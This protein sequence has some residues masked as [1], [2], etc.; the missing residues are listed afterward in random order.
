MSRTSWVLVLVSPL[1]LLSCVL[2][3]KSRKKWRVVTPQDQTATVKS[4]APLSYPNTAEV[5]GGTVKEDPIVAEQQDPAAVA[6]NN[7]TAIEVIESKAWYESNDY[8]SLRLQV[9]QK[10]TEIVLWGKRMQ[11]ILSSRE[12]YAKAT[13]T[14][15]LVKLSNSA[16]QMK[17]LQMWDAVL[18]CQVALVMKMITL[19]Q[20]LEQRIKPD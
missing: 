18:S 3:A 4:P 19:C 14:M 16:D 11:T 2:L 15:E 10:D 17:K 13:E 20:L 6:R 9:A 8:L 1:L 5:I 7:Y 12:T